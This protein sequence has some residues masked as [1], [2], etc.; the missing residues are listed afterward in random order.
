MA[1]KKKTTAEAKTESFKVSGEDLIKKFKEIPH[2]T[3]PDS[4]S[5]LI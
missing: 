5:L 1:T 3:I 2:S 4:L